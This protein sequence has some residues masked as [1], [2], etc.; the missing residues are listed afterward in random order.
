MSVADKAGVQY[1]YRYR[2]TDDI[3]CY[4]SYFD[5]H[6]CTRDANN[7]DATDGTASAVIDTSAAN[8][9]YYVSAP[10]ICNILTGCEKLL[11]NFLIPQIRQQLTVDTFANFVDVVGSVKGFYIY[12]ITLLISVEKFR[13]WLCLC[14]NF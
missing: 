12:Q 10:L 9:H 5:N 4:M 14:L 6:L 11:P 1:S 3:D 7:D 13:L 8:N 2:D